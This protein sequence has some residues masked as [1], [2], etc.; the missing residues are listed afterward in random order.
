MVWR[1]TPVSVSARST[2]HRQSIRKARG[3]VSVGVGVIGIVIVLFGVV[4]VGFI[5]VSIFSRLFRNREDSSSVQ[6]AHGVTLSCPHCGM[7]TE[8]SRPQCQHCKK[9][10]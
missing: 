7:E 10:L 1:R 6:A 4:A 2:I 3:I 8:A 5:G 9:E